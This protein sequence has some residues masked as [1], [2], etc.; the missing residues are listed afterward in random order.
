LAKRITGCGWAYEVIEGLDDAIHKHFNGS[1]CSLRESETTLENRSKKPLDTPM[2]SR[3]GS[4]DHLAPAAQCLYSKYKEDGPQEFFQYAKSGKHTPR[5]KVIVVDMAWD[6]EDPIMPSN[7]SFLTR[8]CETINNIRSF[9]WP[10]RHT[11]QETN[12]LLIKRDT[13]IYDPE[14]GEQ[15]EIS[16]RRQIEHGAACVAALR[17]SDRTPEQ[18]KMIRG[19]RS[20]PNREDTKEANLWNLSPRADII[21]LPIRRHARIEQTTYQRALKQALETNFID[22]DE[23]AAFQDDWSY[24]LLSKAVERDESRTVAGLIE[25]A[26]EVLEEGIQ[27]ELDSGGGASNE[28]ICEPLVALVFQRLHENKYDYEGDP[29]S[30]LGTSMLDNVRKLIS[31][32]LTA[33]EEAGLAETLKLISKAASG[34]HPKIGRGD[35][36]V[37][38]QQIEIWNRAVGHE[39]QDV[40]HHPNAKLSASDFLKDQPLAQPTTAAET[41]ETLDSTY[42]H[43]AADRIKCIELPVI[44]Y[45]A[46]EKAIETLT[47]EH[48]VSVI[49]SGGNSHIDLGQVCIQKLD[50]YLPTER[51]DQL[52]TDKAERR[53]YIN[54]QR[55]RL[56]ETRGCYCG[57]IIVGSGVVGLARYW[58]D[59]LSDR[60]CFD[61]GGDQ[62]EGYKRMRVENHH[63]WLNQSIDAESTTKTHRNQFA[64]YGLPINVSGRGSATEIFHSKNKVVG[65]KTYHHW[66]GASIA[67]MVAAACLSNV[68][69]V[70]QM[71]DYL[72]KLEFADG[73]L[74]EKR[75]TL[76]PLKPFEARAH[77]EQWR[78]NDCFRYDCLEDL[79]GAPPD[80][81]AWFEGSCYF[82]TLKPYRDHGVKRIDKF[83][84]EEDKRNGHS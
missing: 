19:Y 53:E 21:L 6:F 13:K 48:R 17:I 83:A 28:L 35:T 76:F 2:S 77:F 20:D 66:F 56:F 37:V 61:Q 38:P 73:I 29:I 64:N 52:P 5:A 51:F 59:P 70:R 46:V 3:V 26:F 60:F 81:R 49:I 68:Q 63:F 9:P 22:E 10:N 65:D 36:V 54:R 84:K 24:R 45:K 44:A 55:R 47:C 57:A 78:S 1:T 41:P 71:K 80:I 42:R 69:Q 58:L 33:F 32:L 30:G 40:L 15:V 4:F 11:G 31:S 8:E 34:D 72:N 74:D 25:S 62:K 67:S 75:K 23:Y 27:K 50:K 18:R 39:L 14:T 79:M 12:P 7:A 82:D 16:G 43:Q